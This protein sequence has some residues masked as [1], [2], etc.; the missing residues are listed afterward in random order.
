MERRAP[1]KSSRDVG[2]QDATLVEVGKFRMF[3]FIFPGTLA[4]SALEEHAP[5]W[6]TTNG[7]WNL[8]PYSGVSPYFERRRVYAMLDGTDNDFGSLRVGC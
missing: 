6:E 3:P 8:R 5:V 4:I 7:S 1:R 2:L